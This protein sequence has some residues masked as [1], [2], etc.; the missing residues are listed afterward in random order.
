ML[1]TGISM[2]HV[3]ASKFRSWALVF[4]VEDDEESVCITVE[5]VVAH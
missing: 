4:Q 5:W 2:T 1:W 3:V